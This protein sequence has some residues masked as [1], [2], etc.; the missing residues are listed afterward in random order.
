[1][2]SYFTITYRVL[3]LR[4]FCVLANSCKVNIALISESGLEIMKLSHDCT[5][6]SY[7]DYTIDLFTLVSCLFTFF[8]LIYSWTVS[9]NLLPLVPCVTCFGR[10]LWKTSAMKKTQNTFRIT[11]SGGAHT[12]TGMYFKMI[13]QKIVQ[14]YF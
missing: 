12:F 2:I 5:Y 4:D 9:R 11:R 7:Y 10:I 1:M 3:A 14:F 13:T 6:D 8:L